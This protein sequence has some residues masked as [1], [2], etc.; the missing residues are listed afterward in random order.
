M[1]CK[2]SNALQTSPWLVALPNDVLSFI[3]RSHLKQIALEHM[4]AY[5]FLTMLFCICPFISN[6]KKCLFAYYPLIR[7]VARSSTRTAAYRYTSQS[8]ALTSASYLAQKF[9]YVTLTIVYFHYL[10]NVHGSKYPKNMK[11]LILKTVALSKA[12]ASVAGLAETSLITG[13]RSPKNCLVSLSKIVC[14]GS[15]YIK[16][17]KNGGKKQNHW[18]SH[19]ERIW[20]LPIHQDSALQNLAIALAFRYRCPSISRTAWLP[21]IHPAYRESGLKRAISV[22]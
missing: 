13:D 5:S 3:R 4:V 16:Q 9:G 17:Q 11:L 2:Y 14:A 22:E 18:L 10:K 7:D 21:R 8:K 1:T 6:E 20:V 12:L 19:N 15:N